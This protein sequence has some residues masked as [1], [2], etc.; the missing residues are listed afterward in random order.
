MIVFTSGDTRLVPAQTNVI[1]L[2]VEAGGYLY[3]DKTTYEEAVVIYHKYRDDYE[4]LCKLIGV[5]NHEAEIAFVH[6]HLPAPMNFLAPFLTTLDGKVQT[7]GTLSQLVGCL[8]VIS[9]NINFTG[10]IK[11]PAEIRRSVSFNGHIREEYDLQWK[12]F[13][14][15]CV[16]YTM[17][18]D[19]F[20][21]EG[22]F[23]NAQLPT[24]APAASS[25]TTTT[26]SASTT[27]EP[28]MAE[29]VSTGDAVLDATLSSITDDLDFMAMFNEPIDFDDEEIKEE[30]EAVSSTPAPAPTTTAPAVPEAASG[31]DML[32]EWGL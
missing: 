14:N 8:H 1:T 17:I 6:E 27:K 2:E 21:K 31:K 12:E 15:E 23:A 30:L 25:T 10:F 5:E 9:R 24:V 18:Y 32:D 19:V 20:A 4:G 13:I 11:I 7:D 3:V 26:T 16:P 28:V 22:T 29:V